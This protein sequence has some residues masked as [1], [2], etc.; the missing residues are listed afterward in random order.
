MIMFNFEYGPF[1]LNQTTKDKFNMH[2][3]FT[4]MHK[5]FGETEARKEG[6]MKQSTL[7]FNLVSQIQ[8]IN[9]VICYFSYFTAFSW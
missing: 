8:K 1:N 6:Y 4:K 3:C 2:I 9:F 5:I 7:K